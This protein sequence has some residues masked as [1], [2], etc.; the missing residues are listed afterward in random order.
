MEIRRRLLQPKRKQVVWNQ[1]C[2][3]VNADNWRAYGTTWAEYSFA[4]G[5][6]SGTIKTSNYVGYR[7]TAR[8]TE[9]MEYAQQV[10]Q[11][12]KYYFSYE[13]KP[14]FNTTKDIYFSVEFAGGTLSTRKKVLPNVWTRISFLESSSRT[15]TGLCYIPNLQSWYGWGAGSIM[16]VKNPLYVDL[17]KM[18]GVNNE[19]DIETFEKQCT[20]NGVDLLQYQPFDVDGTQRWWII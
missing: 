12:H 11:G 1:M 15:G 17:T 20:K 16:H 3:E 13:V 14:D 7:L 4:D 8:V 5:V 6:A 18:Y 9:N 2:P 10:V 19:P